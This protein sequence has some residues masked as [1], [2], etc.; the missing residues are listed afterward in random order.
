MG[1]YFSFAVVVVCFGWTE[2]IMEEDLMGSGGGG[3]GV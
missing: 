1:E 2:A 3:H